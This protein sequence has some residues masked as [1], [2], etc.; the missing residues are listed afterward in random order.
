[1]KIKQKE[2]IKWKQ[3]RKT[4]YYLRFSCIEGHP[5]RYERKILPKNKKLT[6]L[7][8]ELA[9]I[10]TDPAEIVWVNYLNPNDILP[11]TAKVEIPQF[12]AMQSNKKCVIDDWDSGSIEVKV[13]DNFLQK[14]MYIEFEVTDCS[15]LEIVT[16][17]K[18]DED[19]VTDDWIKAGYPLNWGF[20]E[21][22]K[23]D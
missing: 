20:A 12:V 23:E 19:K 21:N 17:Y 22:K 6:D 9:N 8:L 1:M 7:I 4:K 16:F 18:F 3:D 14:Y 10:K 11:N 15:Y 5:I 2:S 13:P